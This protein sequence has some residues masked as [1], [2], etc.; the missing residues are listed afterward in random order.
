M[1]SIIGLSLTAVAKDQLHHFSHH[2]PLSLLHLQPYHNNENDDDEDEFLE[3]DHLVANETC[4]RNKSCLGKTYKSFK[5]DEHLNLLHCPF[6]DEDDNI[7]KRHTSNQKEFIGKQCDGKVLNHSSHQNPL[8]V[9]DKQ[10]SIDKKVSS[11][12]KS[13]KGIKKPTHDDELTTSGGVSSAGG[14]DGSGGGGR[15]VGGV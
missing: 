6:H 14:N 7:L 11:K 3:E 8:I 12:S 9:F 15:K 10:I 13:T 2:P 5:E 1:G 4:V